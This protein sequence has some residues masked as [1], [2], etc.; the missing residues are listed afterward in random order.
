MSQVK[1]QKG[2]SLLEVV[3]AITILAIAFA[4]IFDSYSENLSAVYRAEQY[5]HA[6]IIAESKMAELYSLPD[7]SKITQSG[8]FREFV[9]QS[10]AS[11]YSADGIGKAGKWQ[12]YLVT[13]R[14]KWDKRREIRLK[15]LKLVKGSG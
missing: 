11:P 4:I 13:V 5:S 7:I 10:S 15:R 12:L 8:R 14:V 1:K 2:F 6:R 3:A 9:W